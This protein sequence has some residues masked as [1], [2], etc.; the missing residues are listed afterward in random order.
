MDYEGS[1]TVI[2]ESS[3]YSL[4]FLDVAMRPLGIE[5]SLSFLLPVS[6]FIILYFISLCVLSTYAYS[7]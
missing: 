4:R 3:K 5:C 7:L 6:L 1:L 2:C